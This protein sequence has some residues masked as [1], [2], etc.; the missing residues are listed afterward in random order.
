[1]AIPKQL[2]EHLRLPLVCAP[3]FLVSGTELAKAACRRG[4]VG[5]LPA[6]NQRS[7]EGFAEWLAEMNRFVETARIQHPGEPIAPYGINLIPH[8]SNPRWQADLELCVEYKV[9]LVITSLSAASKVVDAVHSYGGLVFHD[10]TNTY[11]ARKASDAGVDGIIAVAG[12]A[13]G[14]AGTLNPFALVG[15]IRRFFSGT[16]LLAGALSRGSDILAAQAMGAD[17]AYMGTRFITSR[18]SMADET[19]KEMVIEAS[20]QDIIHTPAVSGVPASFL[21]QSL[22]QAGYDIAKLQNPGPL[23]NT[24][25]LKPLKDEAKAWKSVWSA[26]HGA[27]AIYDRPSATVLCD[28]LCEEYQSAKAALDLTFEV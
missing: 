27:G 22:E 19:Y 10:V 17:L 8:K 12:G 6:L 9:P 21:R 18:E 28:R 26:G 2:A 23:N 20:A 13:G 3:M 16:L 1:M 24:E 14:H 4:V 25:S 7:S 11:H 15:E 5:T